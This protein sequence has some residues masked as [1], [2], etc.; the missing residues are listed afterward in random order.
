MRNIWP[1]L[2]TTLNKMVM[3]VKLVLYSPIFLSNQGPAS[4]SACAKDVSLGENSLPLS[5]SQFS[6]KALAVLSARP[7]R[8]DCTERIWTNDIFPGDPLL[9]LYC[10]IDGCLQ[11]ITK[12]HHPKHY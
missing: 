7:I 12:Q 11:A 1:A 9:S 5:G 8:N 4:C 3:W 10:G 2:A 6:F